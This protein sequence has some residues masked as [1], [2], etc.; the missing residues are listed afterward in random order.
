[1]HYKNQYQSTCAKATAEGRERE[2][3]RERGDFTAKNLCASLRFWGFPPL[4]R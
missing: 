4:L 3:E 1:M 2:T